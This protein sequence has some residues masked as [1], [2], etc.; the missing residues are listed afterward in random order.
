MVGILL[1]CHKT[2]SDSKLEST[3]LHPPN[4][5]ETEKGGMSRAPQK[6]ISNTGK[7]KTISRE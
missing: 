3:R 6:Y 2:A 7:A 1:E 4:G 5:L